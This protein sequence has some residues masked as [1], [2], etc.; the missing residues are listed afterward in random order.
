MNKKSTPHACFKVAPDSTM[1][2]G[3]EILKVLK[4]GLS[5]RYDSAQM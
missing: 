1:I 5:A 2:D 4:R 3:N